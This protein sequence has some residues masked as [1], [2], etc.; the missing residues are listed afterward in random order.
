M[1]T[2]QN[3]YC[4]VIIPVEAI[5][6]HIGT[7]NHRMS[8]EPLCPGCVDRGTGNRTP[9]DSSHFGFCPGKRTIT[10]RGMLEN[11]CTTLQPRRTDLPLRVLFT[12]WLRGETL[13]SSPVYRPYPAPQPRGSAPHRIPHYISSMSTIDPA[14]AHMVTTLYAASD[15]GPSGHQAYVDLYLP[16]ATLIMGP[17]IY[18][19]HKGVQAFRE[20]GWE[21]VSRRRHVCKGMFPSPS[22]PSTEIMTYGTLDYGFKDGSVK[23]GIEWAGRLLLAR[24]DGQPKIAFYQVYIVS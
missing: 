21:K 2:D 20:A 18:N 10:P 19:G 1:K 13:W 3:S 23:E 6:S 4:K 11:V 12:A 22:N 14:A 17:T 24:V 16:D 8:S 7:L 15:V 9:A 5:S